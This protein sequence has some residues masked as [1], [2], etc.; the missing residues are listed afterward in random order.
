MIILEIG[1]WGISQAII[2]WIFLKTKWVFI[3]EKR[4]LLPFTKTLFIPTKIASS[5]FFRTGGLQTFPIQVKKKKLAK[6]FRS[7]FVR[8]FH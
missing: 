6:F 7:L 2:L 1:T 8:D 4:I 5:H 3:Q